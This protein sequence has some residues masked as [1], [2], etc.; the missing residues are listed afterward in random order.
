MDYPAS[1]AKALTPDVEQITAFVHWIHDVAR[2]AASD[3]ACGGRLQIT[4]QHRT[5]L[6]FKGKPLFQ[7]LE[8]FVLGE[9][10]QMIRAA[11]RHSQEGWNCY[12]E[13]RLVR[14]GLGPKERGQAEG[15]TIGVF[16]LV[17]DVDAY[18][19][20]RPAS[21][22][23]PSLVVRSSEPDNEHRW[24]VFDRLLSAKNAKD[25]GDRLRKLGGDANTG[26]PVQP[27]RLA[28]TQNMP[29]QDKRE[30]HGRTDSPTY[31][32]SLGAAFDPNAFAGLLPAVPSTT[33]AVAAKPVKGHNVRL[34]IDET[35]AVL[36]RL[37]KHVR[38]DIENLPAGRDRSSHWFS[39]TGKIKRAGFSKA[40]ARAIWEAF[41]DSVAEKY[42]DRDSWPKTLDDAWP[43]L[44]G[45][46]DPAAHFEDVEGSTA[47]RKA[48]LAAAIKAKNGE[49]LSILKNVVTALRLDPKISACF[50]FDEMQARPMLMRALPD[51][52]DLA[53]PRPVVDTDISVLECYLQ[54]EGL[55][56]IGEGV[57]TRG[58][59]MRASER[60]FNP[61]RD[62][63]NGLRWDGTSRLAGWLGRYLGASRSPYIDAIGIMFLI[64]LVA[65]IRRPG[66]KADH[67]LVLEGAQGAKKST[68]CA[69]LAG[70]WFSDAL[71]DIRQG[72]DAS[73]HLAG[74]WLI[75]VA[76]MSAMGK[77]DHAALK[78]FITRTH[79]RYR[80]PYGKFEVDQP[81]Q[82]IF[83]G[84]TNASVYLRDESGGRRFWPVGVGA[85]DIDALAR[86]R[87]QLFAE[88]V[89]R[90]EAGDP[91]WP[92]ATFEREHIAPEQDA[93]F[94][95]DAWE[96]NL[97]KF[98][99]EQPGS[100]LVGDVARD[101]LFIATSRLGRAEQT[102]ITAAMTRL[103][104]TRQKKDRRGNIP[105][106]RATK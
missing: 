22:A 19:G 27:Y 71:P 105:W 17:I 60:S 102:R 90:F 93:R 67:M 15:D 34:T 89:V 28:G 76:E 43:K 48:W 8:R 31:I 72:K 5:R 64:A 87:D 46:V 32:V 39:C 54:S 97:A 94:E 41:P 20:E 66:V 100:V 18:N 29:S 77:A 1:V 88:A 103:G 50:A 84:T 24:F 36:K 57:T 45:P 91:W 3:G 40:E 21:F 70:A 25:I 95:E 30:R 44:D 63:L 106:A 16:A 79:E 52:P 35:D 73:I 98:L 53:A 2:A 101:A 47:P 58:M 11:V 14:P 80:P 9:R 49:P 33:D 10:E 99:D 96:A 38:H 68:A 74:K 55:R 7:V 37:P 61:V 85:I 92:D 78:A 13:P 75:E 23:V 86:D 6:D 62:Y 4:G 26:N 83:I 42:L 81:R 51:E 59:A 65:R 12:V 56:G 69:V 104:W 82:C